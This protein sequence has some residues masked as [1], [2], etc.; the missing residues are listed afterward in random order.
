MSF[1]LLNVTGNTQQVF[2]IALHIFT[3]FSQ[4][5]AYFFFTFLWSVSGTHI[6]YNVQIDNMGPVYVRLMP[7]N[8]S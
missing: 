3:V 8:F 2:G 7:V 4:I 5:S 6:T 1:T